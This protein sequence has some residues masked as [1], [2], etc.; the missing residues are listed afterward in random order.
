MHFFILYNFYTKKG[1]KLEY[2]SSLDRVRVR[3]R[4]VPLEH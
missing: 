2:K 1:K 3:V 4:V